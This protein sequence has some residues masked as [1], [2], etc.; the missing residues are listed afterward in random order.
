[1]KKTYYSIVL[2]FCVFLS[3]A[4]QDYKG[5]VVDAETGEPIPYVN[6]GVV[7]KGIGTV[8][9][10]EGLFNLYLK[11]N[12]VEPTVKI[13]FSALGYTSLN[14]DIAKMPLTSNEYPIFKMEPSGISLN[15]VVVSNKDG[16][17]IPDVIG[18]KNYGEASFGYW[19]D[20]VALGGELA[21]KI[22]AKKG[23]RRLEKLQFEVF[24]NPSDSLLL[25]VNIYDDD[26]A[27]GFPKANLNTSNR[28]ILVTLKKT[29][30]IIWVD[31]KP[32]DI[33]T[34]DSFM[35][36]LELLKVYGEEK[37]GLVLAAALNRYGSYRKYSSQDGWE[38]ITEQ[39]MAYSLETSLMVSEKMAQRFEK[40]DERKK[41]KIRTLSGYTLRNGKMIA[42]VEVTNSRTKEIIFTDDSGRYLIA[43]NKR[44]E[45]FFKK[46]GFKVMVL[47]V[48]EKPTQ[49]VI[50][51]AN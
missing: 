5:K 37:L 18:Y 42:G 9:D 31:L 15:E 10:E 50:M 47:T 27:L 24:D 13:L 12:E 48:G 7:E 17:F 4:Q 32:F 41:K 44:D 49:N 6:I 30:K 38:I 34:K 19:K 21:T 1:M 11:S 36:S 25:R 16:R 23:L 51:K 35:V 33:Y 20:N 29:D 3:H 40:K 46:D 8:S 22:V 28:N 39:N 2:L 14:I 45:I 43:A 26:G